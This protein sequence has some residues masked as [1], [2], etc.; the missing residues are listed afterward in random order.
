MMMGKEEER[1][2]GEDIIDTNYMLVTELNT[3]HILFKIFP[4]NTCM[5]KTF[6]FFLIDEKTGFKY[7]I[8]CLSLQNL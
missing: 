5:R 8:R 3:S 7:Q 1:I 4:F 2:E 6:N